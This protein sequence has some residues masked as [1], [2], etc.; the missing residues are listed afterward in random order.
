MG[1]GCNI[2][3][4]TD[5]WGDR[6][7]ADLWNIP[8]SILTSLQMRVS[9][10]IVNNQWCL[11]TFLSY[12]DADLA[13]SINT[14]P[15]PVDNLSDKLV[16][17]AAPDDAL[18]HKLAFSFLNGNSQ[19]VSWA[20]LLWN[21]YIPPSRAAISWRLLHNKLP[22]DENLQKRGSYI[23]SICCFCMSHIETSQHIFFQCPITS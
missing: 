9:D 10:C 18:S 4:W 23:V 20:K 11:P 13:T 8:H 12:R 15:L 7:I 22:T 2:N 6:P 3:F 19:K 16:R 17:K 21:A 5:N 14:I 1:N